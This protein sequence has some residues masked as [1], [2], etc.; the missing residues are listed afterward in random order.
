MFVALIV[1]LVVAIVMVALMP[2]PKTESPT[3]SLDTPSVEDGQ[4]VVIHFGRCRVTTPALLAW[5]VIGRTPIQT[6]GGKK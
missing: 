3:A 2:T 6:S 4:S 1:A 5:K